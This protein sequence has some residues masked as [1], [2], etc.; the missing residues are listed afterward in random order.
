MT[1]WIEYE[2]E[3]DEIMER[4]GAYKK[5][6]TRFENFEK[7]CLLCSEP[8]PEKCHRRL[9]AEKVKGASEDTI[10]IIHL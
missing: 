2:A 8:T 4:R 1:S 9:V 10:E 6:V 3:F 7:V 5:F